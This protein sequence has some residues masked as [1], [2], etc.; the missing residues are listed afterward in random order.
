MRV[1]IDLSALKF[2]VKCET[3]GLE[4]SFEGTYFGH[5][6]SKVYQYAMQLMKKFARA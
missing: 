4:E 6:F 1:Q 5:A 2:V 3:L